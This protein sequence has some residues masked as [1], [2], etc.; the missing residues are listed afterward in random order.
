MEP[1][2]EIVKHQT[3][4]DAFQLQEAISRARGALRRV[5]WGDNQDW[6]SSKQYRYAGR[7]GPAQFPHDVVNMAINGYRLY[8]MAVD[9]LAGNRQQARTLATTLRAHGTIQLALA[10]SQSNLVPVALFL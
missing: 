8:D 3:S 7:P 5:A 10:G 9:R 4:F 2:D 1:S 6:D